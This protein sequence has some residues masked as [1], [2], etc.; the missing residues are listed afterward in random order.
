MQLNAIPNLYF[1][2]SFMQI[3]KME[4]DYHS[5]TSTNTINSS[6]RTRDDNLALLFCDTEN[7]VAVHVGVVPENP[8]NAARFK[9]MMA[10]AD[11][12]EWI[13]FA[14]GPE[15]IK[16]DT[17]THVYEFNFGEEL[18]AIEAIR[19]FFTRA[20]RPEAGE[21]SYVMTAIMPAVIG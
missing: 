11:E 6:L 4:L 21:R 12:F 5:S 19:Q 16:F 17:G 2:G 18:I 8:F 7:K 20:V 9:V 15:L 14:S 3:M 10:K 1:C 13:T